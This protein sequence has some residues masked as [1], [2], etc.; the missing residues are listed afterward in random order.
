LFTLF[1]GLVYGVQRHFK[2]IFSYIVT[3]YFIGG[4]NQSIQRKQPWTISWRWCLS[5][6][7]N[8][9]VD[10]RDINCHLHVHSPGLS[11]D[12]DQISSVIHRKS[13]SIPIRGY[14]NAKDINLSF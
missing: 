11:N 10:M 14:L 2:N 7:S 6:G 8:R 5:S 3:V 12:L 13:E 4:G 1:I 9:V